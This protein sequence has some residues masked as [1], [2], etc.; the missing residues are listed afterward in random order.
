M[1]S[2]PNIIRHNEFSQRLEQACERNPRVPTDGVRAGKQKWVRER[3]QEQFGIKVSPEA[4]RKWFA[5]EAKPK[6]A[7]MKAMAE[8]LEVDEAWLALG[9]RPD[10]TPKDKRRRNAVADGAV[11]FLAGLIQMGGGN[12]AFP[13]QSGDK[14]PDLFA[15]IRGR[16]VQIEVKHIQPRDDDAAKFRIYGNTDRTVVCVITTA[17]PMEFDLV[18]VPA[19][20]ISEYGVDKGGYTEMLLSKRGRGWGIGEAALPRIKSVED[21]TLAAEFNS[22]P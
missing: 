17:D 11:N 10:E 16:Q 5:G 20:I 6:Q 18:R 7:I 13:E 1:K 21:L 3:L 2:V 15:I 12:I 19:H 8:I 22:E 9:I 4:T 14:Q